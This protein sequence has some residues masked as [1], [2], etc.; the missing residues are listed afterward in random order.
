MESVLKSW[1]LAYVLKAVTGQVGFDYEIEE[2]AFGGAGIDAAGH[3]LPDATLQACRQAD[4]ILLAAIGSP[5]YD[6]AA[7]RPE[8]GLLQLRKDPGSLCQYPSGENFD[9][10]KD[11]YSPL[12]A[13]RLDGVD[14]V[15]V[16]ELTGGIYFG[17]HVLET[18]QASDSNTYQAKEIERVVRTAFDL[19]QKDE[20]SHQH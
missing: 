18:D 12:K 1:R 17:E 9:S 4:A 19:A 6:D 11:C 8:Q 2:R 7:V 14:L 10:L 3:P 13:D 20:K 5:Q 15:M 16:R